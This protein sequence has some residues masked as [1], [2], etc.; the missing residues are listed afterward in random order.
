MH[1]LSE[2]QKTEILEAMSASRGNKAAAATLLGLPVSTFKSRLVAATRHRSVSPAM[3]EPL[4]PDGQKLRGIS[5]LYKENPVTGEIEAKLQWVKTKEDLDRTIEIIRES[6]LALVKETPPAKPIK[7]PKDTNSD[8]LNLYVLTDY[9]LGMMAK[10]GE[11]GTE[12]N[13]DKAA[14]FVLA[15]F[16]EAIKRAPDA[17]EAFLCQLGDFLHYDSLDAVTPTSRHLMDTDTR[18]SA[19]V[20]TAVYVLKEIVNKLLKKHKKLH[21]LMAEG[22]HDIASS[23]WLRLLFSEFYRNEK[24]VT[25]DKTDN[26]Y[27]AYQFGKTALFFHHGH[28]QKVQGASKVFASIYRKMYG[29]SDYA[30]AHMGDKHHGESKEDGMML[31]EQHPT[32][33]P[34]DAYATRGG[35]VANR[36]A[37]VITYSKQHGEVSRVTV[38]P[39]MLR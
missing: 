18:Y 2:Q 31:V 29:E 35:Y 6:A 4:I 21:I 13:T 38:R 22:N 25:V 32:L 12:W 19:L 36:A 26:P 23:V 20:S 5:T 24:R 3:I 39:E 30:Y 17:E 37:S 14:A 28:K 7:A 8:F 11:C 34:K 33:A 27:Y 15:W 1:P 16:D 9:H 10:A